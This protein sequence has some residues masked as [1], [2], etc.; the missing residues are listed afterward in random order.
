MIQRLRQRIV[1]RRPPVVPE[2]E[3]ECKE[4]YVV[5]G[6]KGQPEAVTK[7]AALPGSDA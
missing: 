3:V 2:G 7:K 6:H 5:A 1:D 4:V